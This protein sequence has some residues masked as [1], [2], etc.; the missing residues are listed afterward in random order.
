MVAFVSRTE[1][2]AIFKKFMK[3]KF[4]DIQGSELDWTHVHET[5][6]NKGLACEGFPN[7][8]SQVT[9]LKHQVLVLDSGAAKIH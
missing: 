7:L 1:T 5:L 9:T 3:F 4:S 8:V 6:V 2:D